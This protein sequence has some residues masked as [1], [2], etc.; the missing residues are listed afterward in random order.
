MI[1]CTP[2]PTSI[3]VRSLIPFLHGKKFH[4]KVQTEFLVPNSDKAKEVLLLTLQ[5]K[6]A[7]F[8]DTYFRADREEIL[9]DI[10]EIM[11]AFDYHQMSVDDDLRTAADMVAEHIGPKKDF[12]RLILLKEYTKRQK[13]DY[14]ILVIVLSETRL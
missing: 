14:S 2:L 1:T 6:I 11:F 13:G 7:D 12:D 9:I 4:R 8:E 10:W 3:L 5:K